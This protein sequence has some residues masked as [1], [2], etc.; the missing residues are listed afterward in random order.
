MWRWPACKEGLTLREQQGSGFGIQVFATT[1]RLKIWYSLS[2]KKLCNFP[3]RRI[4]GWITHFQMTLKSITL[5]EKVTYL[6]EAWTL[7]RLS[8]MFTICIN[9][10]ALVCWM[11][12]WHHQI[13]WMPKYVMWTPCECQNMCNIQNATTDIYDCCWTFKFI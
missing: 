12:N 1:S 10:R 2:S 9:W 7:L 8:S 4:P 3:E 11:W 13:L 5:D 6:V